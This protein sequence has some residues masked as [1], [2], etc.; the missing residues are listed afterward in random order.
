ML[1]VI[2]IIERMVDLCVITKNTCVH[3]NCESGL[4]RS[5]IYTSTQGELSDAV[6]LNNTAKEREVEHLKSKNRT[7]NDSFGYNTVK[8]GGLQ[9]RRG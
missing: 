3:G 2:V 4:E 7:H 9:M 8:L 5:N 1:L 6:P